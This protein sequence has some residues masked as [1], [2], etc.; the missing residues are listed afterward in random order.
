M[1]MR[2]PFAI[3]LT[4]SSCIHLATEVQVS[5][6]SF[7]DLTKEFHNSNNFDSNTSY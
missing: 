5:S 7:L 6:N 1:N 4:P 2:M 3:C